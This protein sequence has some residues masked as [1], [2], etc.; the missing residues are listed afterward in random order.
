MVLQKTAGVSK[1]EMSAS[2]LNGAYHPVIRYIYTPPSGEAVQRIGDVLEQ[3]DETGRWQFAY[4][5]DRSA[6]QLPTDFNDRLKATCG[7][8]YVIGLRDAP[9]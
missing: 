7:M 4:S 6:T 5:E 9:L 3:R 8:P 1:V 2:W